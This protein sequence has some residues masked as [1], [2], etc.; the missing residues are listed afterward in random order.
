MLAVV[1][2]LIKLLRLMSSFMMLLL[3]MRNRFAIYKDIFRMA[4]EK[5]EH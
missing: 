1:A 5:I 2:D 3:M 4:E